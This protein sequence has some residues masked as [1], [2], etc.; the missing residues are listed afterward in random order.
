MIKILAVCALLAAGAQAA[1]GSNY[2]LGINLGE[3]SNG[4]GFSGLNFR[5][6]Q[7]E[8][9]D[10]IAAWNAGGGGSSTFIL[11]GN[12]L[13]HTAPILPQIPIKGVVPY[14][15]IGLG[16]WMNDNSGAWVQ[17]PLGIDLRFS[18]PV[19]VSVYIAPGIDLIPSTQMNMHFGVGVRYW[20]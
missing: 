13:H 9:L 19:E 16:L 10:L 7:D 15:G 5:V 4:S 12:Y 11:N 8:T 20:L 6:G 14:A 2:A 17:I 18:A 1:T 3:A